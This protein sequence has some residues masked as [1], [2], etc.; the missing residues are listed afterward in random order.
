[1]VLKN[2]LTTMS[3]G[4][5]RRGRRRVVRGRAGR[6]PDAPEAQVLS[7]HTVDQP[8]AATRQSTRQAQNKDIGFEYK[9]FNLRTYNSFPF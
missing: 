1:M 5:P 8:G 3:P 9:P 6:S 2:E 7:T 4:Y